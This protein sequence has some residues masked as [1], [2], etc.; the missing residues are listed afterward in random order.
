LGAP[1]FAL[2]KHQ[3]IGSGLC[4]LDTVCAVAG[5]MNSL[6]V[7]RSVIECVDL[8][9]GAK[10]TV[11]STC[12]IQPGQLTFMLLSLLTSALMLGMKLASVEIIRLEQQE[13]SRMEAER[14]TMLR[15]LQ[16]ELQA[17][18]G[19]P[20]EA[21]QVEK[22][23]TARRSR[24]Y[25]LGP[26][27][28]LPSPVVA[29][30][31][32]AVY[33]SAVGNVP[34]GAEVA[35][36]FRACLASLLCCI[37]TG[38]LPGQRLVRSRYAVW[39][40]SRRQMRMTFMQSPHSSPHHEQ[41]ATA[42]E[43]SC[44]GR[45]RQRSRNLYILASPSEKQPCKDSESPLAK[46][47]L[48]LL[49]GSRSRLS[50]GS[51]SILTCRQ[52]T[53]TRMSIMPPAR[54]A[55]ALGTCVAFIRSTTVPLASALTLYHPGRPGRCPVL[56]RTAAVRPAS[57]EGQG[58]GSPGERDLGPIPGPH[59]PGGELAGTLGALLSESPP[60]R[61]SEWARC[62]EPLDRR[63]L[64][65]GRSTGERPGPLRAAASTRQRA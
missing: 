57:V 49:H 31:D 36:A 43:L 41:C 5:T 26:S 7:I 18:V 13:M 54:S 42:S 45:G 48:W 52:L 61:D 47:H 6:F 29:P 64:R 63:Q 27:S 30:T 8:A 15:E 50:S 24:V 28:V 11:S 20:E 19:S 4:W 16:E 51:P 58:R 10:S 34:A 44:T 9:T 12:D 65:A 35:P 21:R 59:P 32:S 53:R 14:D 39:R 33:D 40:Y 22:V 62:L 23:F 56:P 46:G 38:H 55:V 17:A 2:R 60:G 37:T 3:T 1:L 25:T